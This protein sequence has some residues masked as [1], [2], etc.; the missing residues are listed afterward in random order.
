MPQAG[1]QHTPIPSRRDVIDREAPPTFD[2]DGAL[3]D[4]QYSIKALSALRIAADVL[5]PDDTHS[6]DLNLLSALD[7]V[8]SMAAFSGG[9]VR[10]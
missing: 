5:S 8:E 4:L 10:T 6:D 1:R 2:L 7:D 9:E 3:I